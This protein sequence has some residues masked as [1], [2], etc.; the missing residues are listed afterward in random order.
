M[1]LPA[2]SLGPPPSLAKVEMPSEEGSL[3]LWA[4]VPL[5]AVFFNFEGTQLLSQMVS[6]GLV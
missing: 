1:S 5:Q 4:P 2:G 6:F 3:P